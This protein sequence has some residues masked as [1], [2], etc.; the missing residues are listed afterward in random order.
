VSILVLVADGYLTAVD[1]R[2]HPICIEYSTHDFSIVA[3]NAEVDLCVLQS[4]IPF[5]ES[6]VQQYSSNNFSC[7]G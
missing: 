3:G 2:Y 1:Y 4:W 5:E 6:A 7:Y